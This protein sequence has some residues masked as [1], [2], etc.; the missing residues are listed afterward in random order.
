MIANWKYRFF[1]TFIIVLCTTCIYGQERPTR[2]KF[3]TVTPSTVNV[4]AEGGSRV[5]AVNASASWNISSRPQSWIQLSTDDKSLH[6]KV[7]ENKETS[8]RSSSFELTADGKNVRVSV[9]QSGSNISLSVSSSN[10]YFN[11]SGGIK[12]ITV[13][14]NGTW[15]IGSNTITW[16][17]VSKNG[18]QLSIRADK[19]NSTSQRSG[20][21][22][23]KAGNKEQRINISQ[24]GFVDNLSVSSENLD[25][26]SSGGTKTITITSSSAWQIGSNTLTWGHVSKNENQLSIRVDKNNGTSQRSG[27][28]IIKAG[29][30]ERRIYISQSA[31][32]ANLSVSSENLNFDSS[33]G[34]KILSINTNE[35]WQIK[36]STSSWIHFEKNGSQLNV[37]IDKNT[38]RD[39]RTDRFI[40]KTGTIEKRIT[41]YQEG[42]PTYLSVSDDD[43]YFS[44]NGGSQDITVNSNKDWNISVNTRSWGKLIRNG[45]MLTVRVE[46]NRKKY[47]RTDYFKLRAEEKVINVNVTQSG[48]YRKPFNHAFDNYGGGL[49]LGYIQKQWVYNQD[50]ETE[51]TG[52]FDGD[53]YLQGIQVGLRLDPQ[54]GAGFGFNSGLFYEFCW[55]KSGSYNNNYGSYHITYNEHGLYMPLHLKFTMNFSKWFQLSL[56]G[57]TGFNYVLSGKAKA[58]MDDDKKNSYTENVFKEEEDWR[59]FNIMLEYGVALRIGAIQF[60]FTMSQGLKNWS[61]NS[62]YKLKVGRPMAISTTICF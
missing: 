3:L 53:K 59:R 29:N 18:N 17:H 14:T 11:S 7:D 52:V 27:S 8:P 1:L 33:G 50:G 24:S 30:K 34:T 43:L 45:N 25:F 54:F 35:T 5:I 49:S 37:I 41:V 10:M 26:D 6:I 56:Y 62:D 19:N 42:L 40:V 4:G 60:D 28:I 9:K 31:F 47:A 21:I 15:Q 32:V 48:K 23:I 2:K 51:K 57:G 55:A 13:T 16:G 46:P 38:N 58:T 61:D 36:E 20:S 12:N 22:I 44:S 39:S